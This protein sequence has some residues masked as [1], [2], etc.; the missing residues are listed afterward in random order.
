[1]PLLPLLGPTVTVHEPPELAPPDL[2]AALSVLQTSDMS[3]M[4]GVTS[5]NSV[6]LL[7]RGRGGGGDA[8]YRKFGINY[9]M[10]LSRADGQAQ[11]LRGLV[12][13]AAIELA[14]KL[15]KTPYWACLNG[16]PSASEEIRHEIADWYYAMAAHPQEIVG[17]FQNQMRRRGFYEGPAD[18]RRNAAIE[19]AVGR[20]RAALGLDPAAGIDEALFTAYLAADHARI[21][22]PAEPARAAVAA[23]AATPE[24]QA[25]PVAAGDGVIRD[26]APRAGVIRDPAPRA[27][28]IRDPA[29]R[30]DVA[31]DA[32][33]RDPA[34]RMVALR[35]QLSSANG[36][37]AFAR[38]E[39]VRLLLQPTR[40]AHVYC[41]LQDEDARLRRIY[42]NRFSTSTLVPATRPLALPGHMRFELVMNR[43]GVHETVACFATPHNVT[44]QLP[45]AVVG[46]DFEPLA[47][48][49]LDQVRSAFARASAGEVAMGTFQVQA[50]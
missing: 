40:D 9:S 36:Q 19:E 18:G 43:R 13:L 3:V 30:E 14:G 16:E 42:P 48:A 26:P 27:G 11:A 2:T 28:V 49:S 4:P 33:V 37:K 10:S 1:M 46:T 32:V 50:R 22:R 44:A 20:Y 7:S 5:R 34:P 35:L 25:Q 39:P 29:P 17:W 15:T 8:A 31:G 24:A 41:Y 23:P 45:A 38:G 47:T 12:E 6:V 21:A